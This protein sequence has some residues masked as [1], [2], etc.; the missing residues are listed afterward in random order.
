MERLDDKVAVVTGGGSGIGLAMAERF[1]AEGMLVVIADIEQSALER[2]TATLGAGDRLLAVS[3]DV[4]DPASV[5]A[6]AGK[7]ARR[8]GA[9]HV[10]C[11]NAGVGGHFGLSWETP[12]AEWE[13]MFSVNVRGV[14]HGVRSF[15][16]GLIARGEG[17][18]VNTASIA[19]WAGVPTMGPYC[20]SKH[21]VVGMSESLRRELA[22]VGSGVGVSVL[23]PGMVNS[24]IISSERNWPASLGPEPAG[25]SDPLTDTIRSTLITGTTEGPVDPSAAAEAT[26]EGILANRF[27]VTT[28]PEDLVTA[29]ERRIAAAKGQ[30]PAM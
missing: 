25:G 24:R 4:S 20:A 8:F 16:P 22:L 18:V 21:A 11:N 13:W 30:D 9:V 12:L 6:L 2:A 19:G 3:T 29:A 28:H 1:L 14:I 10:I 27:V 26:V 17:H 23:C 15:V 5:D 7:A